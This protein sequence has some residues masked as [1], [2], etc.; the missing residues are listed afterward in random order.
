MSRDRVGLQS[1]A[2]TDAAFRTGGVRSTRLLGVRET[3][4]PTGWGERR[5]RAVRDLVCVVGAELLPHA[6]RLRVR[7]AGPRAERAEFLTRLGALCQGLPIAAQW[8]WDLT[9]ADDE[10]TPSNRRLRGDGPDGV[11]SG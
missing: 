4:L 7:V 2:A 1:F 9:E 5:R 8:A 6:R 11:A 3:V 10:G